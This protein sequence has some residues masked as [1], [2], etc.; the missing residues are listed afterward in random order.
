MFSISRILPTFDLKSG[1]LRSLCSINVLIRWR[2]YHMYMGNLSHSMS[3]IKV[4]LNLMV[5]IGNWKYDS[6]LI[7]QMACMKIVTM[8]AG[9]DKQLS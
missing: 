1:N 5:I 8:H 6:K 7:G 2:S 4:D 3:K 9:C